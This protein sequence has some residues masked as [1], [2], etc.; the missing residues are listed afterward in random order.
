MGTSDSSELG[1]A[2]ARQV[3]LVLS[4]VNTCVQEADMLEG[5]VDIHMHQRQRRHPCD[6]CVPDR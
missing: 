2:E 6:R 1:G 4:S 3:G 5:E